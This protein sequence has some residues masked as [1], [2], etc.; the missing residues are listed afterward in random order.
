MN[1]LEILKA[2]KEK[3]IILNLVNGY[4]RGYKIEKYFKL[5]VNIRTEITKLESNKRTEIASARIQ[6]KFI[7][8]QKAFTVND[9]FNLK[10]EQ[11]NIKYDF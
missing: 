11:N 8:P 1:R 10:D 5:M 4:T 9:M 3:L 2:R 6:R 7:D